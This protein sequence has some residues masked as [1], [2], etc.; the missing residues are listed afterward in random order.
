MHLGIKNDWG[1]MAT[2]KKL[3]SRRNTDYKGHG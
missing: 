3:G 1:Q 2:E